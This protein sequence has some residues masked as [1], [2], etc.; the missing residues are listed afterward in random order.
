MLVNGCGGRRLDNESVTVQKAYCYLYS[1]ESY[2]PSIMTDSP[3]TNDGS[4][5]EGQSLSMFLGNT[6]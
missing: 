6:E 4:I 3:A 5:L 2:T 1:P